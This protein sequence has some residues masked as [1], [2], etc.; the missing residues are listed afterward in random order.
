MKCFKIPKNWIPST[1]NS[2]HKSRISNL[3]AAEPYTAVNTALSESHLLVEPDKQLNQMQ[4]MPVEEVTN[5]N[6]GR[7]SDLS[8]PPGFPIP[9]FLHQAHTLCRSQNQPHDLILSANATSK[10]LPTDEL[11]GKEGAK[12]WESHFAPALDSK[13][14]IQVPSDWVNFLAVN[15]LSPDKFAWAKRFIHSNI[16]D[17][18]SQS[19]TC[20][21]TLPFSIPTKCPTRDFLLCPATS[22]Q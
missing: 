18:I 5:E 19:S 11:L 15:F 4:I 1:W 6:D 3:P 14:I 7:S 2:S 21:H 17:I 13:E 9:A 8:A 10:Q 12:I 22:T 16:W 20:P